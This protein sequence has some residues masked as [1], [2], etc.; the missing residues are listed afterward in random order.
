[1]TKPNQPL[2]SITHIHLSKLSR[3]DNNVRTI[4]PDSKAD[5]ELIA[6]IQSQGILQNLVVIPARKK[7]H[8]EV[9][10]GGRRLGALQSLLKAEVILET[11][12]V[13]CLVT[14]NDH[15]TT[16]SL[17]E[18]VQRADM[19]PADQFMAFQRLLEQGSSVADISASFGKTQRHVNRMLALAKVH[20]TIIQSFK[21]DKIN[22]DCVEAFTVNPDQE[23]QLKCF[24]STGGN[25]FANNIRRLLT[26]EKVRVNSGLG[27][28]VGVKRYKKAGGTITQDLFEGDQYFDDGQLVN[29]IAMGLLNEALQETGD[30]WKW[31]EAQLDSD[32]YTLK[33]LEP[34]YTNVPEELSQQ[35]KDLRKQL[36]D[37]GADDLEDDEDGWIKIEEQLKQAVLEREKYLDYTDDQK[38]FSGIIATINHSGELKLHKGLVNPVDIKAWNDFQREGIEPTDAE[39]VTTEYSQALKYDLRAHDQ[40]MFKLN[41]MQNPEL[42]AE[43]F[44]FEF[45]YQLLTG[46]DFLEIARVFYL[47]LDNQVNYNSTELME[48]AAGVELR[49]LIGHIDRSWIGETLKDSY[50][51]FTKLPHKRQWEIF[52]HCTALT[53]YAS[54]EE[55][56]RDSIYK[57]VHDR[58]SFNK[59]NYWKPT[60]DNFFNRLSRPVLE[61]T[62]EELYGYEWLYQRHK[63]KKGDLAQDCEDAYK[64][65]IGFLPETMRV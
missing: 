47:N 50:A 59:T 17:T 29:E 21:E 16:A 7:G 51:A 63:L 44:I 31:K 48:S 9:V 5:K 54:A 65:G 12:P 20:P 2:P 35:I 60:K 33:S 34:V 30:G 56:G 43:G 41:M 42:A 3:S 39:E 62:A 36:D 45:C 55:A 40:I 46:K 25:T 58:T 37:F 1:M 24:E 8:Y 38:R 28:F 15:A 14:D 11:Y 49:K 22:L 19:H 61:A 64:D 52:G 57:P 53:A 18:N 10:A 23:Q 27:K 26:D 32:Y 4:N 13:P 6:S